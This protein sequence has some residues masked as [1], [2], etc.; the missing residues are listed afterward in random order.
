VRRLD[1]VR[2]SSMACVTTRRRFCAYIG[3]LALDD[4][5]KKT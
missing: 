1:G 3:P 2:D 5:C 4:D